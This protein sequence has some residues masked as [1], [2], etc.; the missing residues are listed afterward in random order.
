MGCQI[1]SFQKHLHSMPCT[2][3]FPRICRGFSLHFQFLGYF[4]STVKIAGLLYSAHKISPNSYGINANLVLYAL[5]LLRVILLQ[6]HWEFRACKEALHQMVA[7]RNCLISHF[8]FFQN[9]PIVL[10][11]LFF[12]PIR[13]SE[14]WLHQIY[15][16]LI[17]LYV[18]REFFFLP[19]GFSTRF[20]WFL[21]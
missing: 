18:C 11:L 13:I 14:F 17:R 20:V 3:Q 4:F 21:Y 12:S 6:D 5:M 8:F 9:V 7:P 16:I 15:S 1:W 10:L 2:C 19:L